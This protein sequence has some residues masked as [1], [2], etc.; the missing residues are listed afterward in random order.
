[1]AEEVKKSE[2]KSAEA[3]VGTSQKKTLAKKKLSKGQALA[4]E[5]CGLSV[6]VEEIGDMLV[7]EDSIL[8]CCGKP[9][10]QKVATK[11]AAKN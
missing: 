11:K 5:V 1:M 2:K 10:K 6:V 3:K 7:E 9:M 4:C 8:L